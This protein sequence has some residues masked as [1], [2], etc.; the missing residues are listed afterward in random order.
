M[1]GQT[2]DEFKRSL[3]KAKAMLHLLLSGVADLLQLRRRSRASL[4]CKVV[5]FKWDGA[6]LEG[7]RGMLRAQSSN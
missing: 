7:S 1:H 3:L 4:A 5:L 6:P 2:T